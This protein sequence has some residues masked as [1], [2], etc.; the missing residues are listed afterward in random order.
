MLGKTEG[1]K[2]RGQWRTLWLDGITDSMGMSLSKLWKI[3]KDREAWCATVHGVTK[4]WTRLSKWITTMSYSYRNVS[5]AVSCIDL[6]FKRIYSIVWIIVYLI[7]PFLGYFQHSVITNYPAV[8]I[9]VH[10]SL[11]RWLEYYFCSVTQSC[12]TVCNPMDC[13]TPGFPVLHCFPEFAQTYVHWVDDAIQPSHPL[14]PPSLP[15]LNL[16]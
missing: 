14:L 3:V 4:S 7:S 6:A 13:S 12:P 16:S 11:C 10:P 9:H 1:K 8:K 2:K 15:T 5:Q